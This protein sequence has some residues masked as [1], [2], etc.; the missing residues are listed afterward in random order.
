EK[1]KLIYF[2]YL[3]KIV[4]GETVGAVRTY[5]GFEQRLKIGYEN[6]INQSFIINGQQVDHEN[7]IN[8]CPIVTNRI[9]VLLNEFENIWD[10]N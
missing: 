10:C 8:G 4:A 1:A 3:Q 7:Y 9:D 5:N 2:N 6:H